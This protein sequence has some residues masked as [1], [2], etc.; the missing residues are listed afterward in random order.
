MGTVYKRGKIWWLKYYQNGK[1]HYESSESKKKRDAE[2]ILKIREGDVGRG[3]PVAP[4]VRKVTLG[5]LV[6]DM[7]NDYRVNE[8][9]TLAG[10][11]ARFN[12]HVLP[13]FGSGSRAVDLTT[14]RVR[15]YIVHRQDEGAKNGTINRELTCL[16]RAFSL[17]VKCDP[18]KLM[19][20]PYIPMLKEAPPRQGFLS[21]E[22]FAAVAASLPDHLKGLCTFLYITGWRKQEAQSL[23]WPEVD[24]AEGWVTVRAERSKNGRPRRFPMTSEL[25][26]VLDAQRAVRRRFQ[27]RGR[28]VARVFCKPNGQPIGDFRKAWATACKKAGTPGTLVH[29]LRRSAIR[30]LTRSGVS[31]NVAMQLSGHRTRSVFDRYDITSEADLRHAAELLEKTGS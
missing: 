13:Y 26:A 10:V 15:E 17:A 19:H 8:R 22:Q 6:G 24:M 29:D 3:K 12:L 11:E 1:P 14:A 30:N 28:I 31:D 5:E 7:L 20:K 25:S 4:N 27:G 16:K 2:R 21:P 18:P 9:K 23:E